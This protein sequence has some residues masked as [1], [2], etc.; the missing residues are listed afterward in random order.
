MEAC[1]LIILLVAYVE[2]KKLLPD[3]DIKV[4]SSETDRFQGVTKPSKFK[5]ALR[6]GFKLPS[7]IVDGGKDASNH[8][9]KNIIGINFTL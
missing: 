6:S 9:A 5:G 2:A 3:E 8:I 1:L 7:L 4:L